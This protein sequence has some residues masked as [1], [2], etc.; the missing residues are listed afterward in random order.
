MGYVSPAHS[1]AQQAVTTAHNSRT[2]ARRTHTFSTTVTP[3][4]TYLSR[5]TP[6]DGPALARRTDNRLM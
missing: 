1:P 2:Q 3:G 4:D 6:T 5:Q